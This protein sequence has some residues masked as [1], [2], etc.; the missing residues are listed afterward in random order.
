[1]KCRVDD[2]QPILVDDNK[3]QLVITG[4]SFGGMVIYSALYHSMMERAAKGESVRGSV[5]A[6]QYDIARSFGDIVLLVN[7]AFEGTM[8]EPLFNIAT[9]RCYQK[10]QRPVMMIATSK[11]DSATRVAFPI[12][13]A[14]STVN[15]HATS[16]EQRKSMLKTIGREVRYKTHDLTLSKGDMTA[17]ESDGSACG[18]PH[19]LPTSKVTLDTVLNGSIGSML[20]NNYGKGL[21]LTPAA[22]NSKYATNYPYLVVTTDAEIIAGHNAIYNNKFTTFTQQF[23]LKHIV[24]KQPLPA[25]PDSSACW[26]DTSVPGSLVP[27]ERSCRLSDGSACTKQ[28]SAP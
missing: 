13:R 24:F 14:I 16:S 28:T 8:Y 5:T 18:C 26:R 15:E 12:G 27:Y 19:L 22:A 20:S 23:L 21:N 4:H 10:S 3:A 1:M 2:S 6:V 9:N 17:D 25:A 7:P 11:A